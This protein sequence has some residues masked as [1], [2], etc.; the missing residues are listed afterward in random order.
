MIDIKM[1]PEI[2]QAI[3]ELQDYY[4]E[5]RPL[6]ER[7]A[8]T[9]ERLETARSDFEKAAR[10]YERWESK[11][12]NSL[13]HPVRKLMAAVQASVDFVVPPM[14]VHFWRDP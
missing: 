14:V 9:S 11:H 5:G 2:E 7:A 12:Q 6:A 1:T 8:W 3:K 13:D 10:E 4:V